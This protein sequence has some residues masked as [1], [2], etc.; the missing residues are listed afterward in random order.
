[1]KGAR[2]ATLP[3]S[4]CPTRPTA[5]GGLGICRDALL[6]VCDAAR[7]NT[8]IFGTLVVLDQPKD[9][10]EV[11]H[12]PLRHLHHDPG[13]HG[14]GIDIPAN[15]ADTAVVA[16]LVERYQH[17]GIWMR[18]ARGNA[19]AFDS[20][21]IARHASYIF[22]GFEGLAGILPSMCPRRIE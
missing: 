3:Q 8:H 11:G 13:V 20:F 7:R 19:D 10:H 2:I 15:M 4:M 1:M 6:D 22:L 17:A 16:D 12:D 14:V 5:A 9:A 21:S 18:T